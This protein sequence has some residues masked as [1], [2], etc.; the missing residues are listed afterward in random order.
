[1]GSELSVD[2]KQVP[3]AYRKLAEQ[4]RERATGAMAAPVEEIDS[5][6]YRLGDY[7]GDLSEYVGD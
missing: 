3:E 1:M 5:M 4:Y 7:G 2:K 6:D